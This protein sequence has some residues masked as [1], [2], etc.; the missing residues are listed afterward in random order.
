MLGDPFQHPG[1]LR[2][3]AV[4]HQ[5]SFSIPTKCWY[6]GQQIYIYVNEYGSVVL[7]DELGWPWPK[8]DCP[9]APADLKGHS[10][11]RPAAFMAR[12]PHGH[13]RWFQTVLEDLEAKGKDSSYAA[14]TKVPGA[15]LSGQYDSQR[16]TLE[17]LRHLSHANRL[18]RG[19]FLPLECASCTA[20]VWAFVP[21]S[22][23]PYIAES[24]S[25]GSFRPHRCGTRGTSRVSIVRACLPRTV[26]WREVE[27][28]LRAASSR[29]RPSKPEETIIG[30]VTDQVDGHLRIKTLLGDVMSV[31]S[32]VNHPIYT[33]VVS[34][35]DPFELGSFVIRAPTLEQFMHGLPGSMP[36]IVSEEAL[37]AG[38]SPAG[39]KSLLPKAEPAKPAT[40]KEKV[41]KP[42]PP[43]V[44]R[45]P[46]VFDRSEVV[47]FL[48]TVSLD[49]LSEED[50]QRW[51]ALEAM[52]GWHLGGLV[53]E[54]LAQR[55][56]SVLQNAE[57]QPDR[58]T[59]C[60][61]QLTL[62]GREI[63]LK[64]KKQFKQRKMALVHTAKA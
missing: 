56:A 48:K 26:S 7:F 24:R 49:T 32:S 33:L 23:D 58:R 61:S 59:K 15:V 55:F 16:P 35:P 30:F 50:Q 17:F 29:S 62:V 1:L 43:V 57:R 9:Q 21:T 46:H 22:G 10:V 8:H 60:L 14:A 52:H 53:P 12:M 34:A 2:Q 64:V 13:S 45:Y 63:A 36:K 42:K 28:R 47:T 41:V 39:T 3:I 25:D 40:Q 18:R 4:R 44:P 38:K 11:Q 20:D 6:C 37:R 19:L 5:T 54:N 31:P 51:N 27:V